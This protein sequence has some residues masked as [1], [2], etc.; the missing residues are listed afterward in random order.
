MRGRDEETGDFLSPSR[1]Q[2]RREALAVFD[3]GEKLVALTDSQ[4]ARV[5]MPESLRDMVRESRRITSPGARK[6]QLQFLAKHMRRED[7]DTLDAIRRSLEHDRADARRETA[8]LHRFEAMREHLIEGGDAALAELVEAHPHAD[9]Q[10][11]RQLARNAR[12][13]RLQQQAAARVPPVV[14]RTQGPRSA[15]SRPTSKPSQESLE[16]EAEP[17]RRLRR[18]GKPGFDDLD[19]HDGEIHGGE[20]FDSLR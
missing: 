9:R 7:D 13:E 20:D 18:S 6:R 17:A 5:P 11:L 19:F 2:K 1:S 15:A 16:H 8:E 10:H 12:E 3:L 14:P 4:L